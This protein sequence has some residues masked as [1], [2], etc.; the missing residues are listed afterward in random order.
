MSIDVYW[1]MCPFRWEG[2][3]RVEDPENIS[4]KFLS[5]QPGSHFYSRCPSTQEHL[6]NLYGLRQ[7]Y[8][9]NFDFDIDNKSIYADDEETFNM[10]FIRSLENNLFSWS[11]GYIFFTEKDSLIME[12]LPAYLED[13][14]IVNKTI[15]VPGRID[16]GKWFRPLD[17]AFHLKKENRKCVLNFNLDDIITYVHFKTDE[18]I[19]LKYYHMN[20]ELS[21]LMKQLMNTKMKKVPDP[22]KGLEW[23]YNII[24]KR[25]LKPKILKHIKQNIA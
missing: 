14:K 17:F 20:S 21:L 24:S 22:R 15:M 23:F 18:K 1:S 4:K 6:K 16:I 12:V 19:N 13:N 7:I 5:E 11:T 2:A 3:Y 25:K 10:L 8:D 9:A